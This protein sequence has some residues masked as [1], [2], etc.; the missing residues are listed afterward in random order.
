MIRHS[1]EWVGAVAGFEFQVDRPAENEAAGGEGSRPDD[2]CFK[3]GPI[4][5]GCSNDFK[6]ASGAEAA[7]LGNAACY[8][9]S[10][11]RG[12]GKGPG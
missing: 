5:G 12:I 3:T 8:V 2:P 9:E 7:A 10:L 4:E 11:V 6:P 1:A